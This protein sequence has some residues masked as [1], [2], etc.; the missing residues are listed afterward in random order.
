VAHVGRPGGNIKM[1]IRFVAD[2]PISVANDD[3]LG[4]SS[5]AERIYTSLQETETPFVYGLLGPWGSGKTSIQ[6]LL[7]NKFDKAI[8]VLR[9]TGAPLGFRYLYVPIWLDAWKYENQDNMIFPL[10]Y[11]FRQKRNELIGGEATAGFMKSLRNVTVATTMS[12]LDLGLR[13]ITKI[14]TGDAMK[15]KEIKETLELV[16]KDFENLDEILTMWAKNVDGLSDSYE[17]FIH[18]FATEIAHKFNLQNQQVRFIVFIDDLDR[19]LPDIAVKVLEAVK[20]HLS[21]RDCVYLLGVNPAVI[22]RGIRTKYQGSDISGR[23][24]LEKI[25][26]YSFEVP[27]SS[28]GMLRV[29]GTKQLN[30]L[31]TGGTVEERQHYEGA[32]KTFGEA[33][34]ACSFNNPRKIKRILNTYLFY[35]SSTSNIIGANIPPEKRLDLTTIVKLII[36]AA[37]YPEFFHNISADETALDTAQKALAG[38]KEA[39]ELYG[40]KYGWDLRSVL[41]ELSRMPNLINM[42]LATNRPKLREHIAS[43]RD[44]ARRI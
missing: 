22:D 35:I 23:E 19:C 26:N 40:S 1:Q 17:E 36:L 39:L 13:G 4:F 33:L 31:L 11:A 29:Y 16:E 20:N 7:A 24:Y 32:L 28:A 30:R 25:L 10:L 14:A 15:L 38:N 18:S 43:V 34:E 6:R 12:V 8:Q 5:Y 44:F 37:Y 42:Q 3:D 9:S 41:S 27:Q 21:V 2:Y